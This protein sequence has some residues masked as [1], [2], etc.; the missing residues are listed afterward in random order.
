VILAEGLEDYLRALV[1]EPDPVLAEMV[2]HGDRDGIPIVYPETGLLLEVLVSLAGARTAVEVGTAIGVS[3]LHIARALQE[4][5]SVISFEIDAVRYEA[6]RRY[7][8]RAGVGDRADLR[9]QDGA[10]GLESLT[11][12]FDFAFLDAAK[13]DYPRHLELVVPL[14]RPGGAVAIDNV[15]LSGAVA[16]DRVVSHWSEEDVLRMRAFNADLIADH[17]LTATVLSVGDGVSVAVRR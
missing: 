6:A 5:G 4:G 1:P 10:E 9:L 8:D 2:A 14:L 17:G 15:L 12:P 13:G 16:S 11:G 3:T 7:L